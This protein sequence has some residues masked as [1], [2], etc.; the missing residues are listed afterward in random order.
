MVFSHYHDNSRTTWRVTVGRHKCA[1]NVG[2]H[3]DVILSADTDALCG[4]G[5]DT[6]L[7][8]SVNTSRKYSIACQLTSHALLLAGVGCRSSVLAMSSVAKMVVRPVQ[9][10]S[11]QALFPSVQQQTTLYHPHLHTTVIQLQSC[12]KSAIEN[13]LRISDRSD[14]MIQ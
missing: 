2:H 8:L 6:Q 10:F 3:F 9:V 5:A 1:D 4:V 7:T 11:L 12:I 13:I 14:I